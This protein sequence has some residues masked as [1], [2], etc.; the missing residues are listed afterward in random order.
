MN[1]REVAESLQLIAESYPGRWQPTKQTGQVWCR[2]LSDIDPKYG[3]AAVTELC[4]SGDW[5][6]SIAQ[7]RKT[8]VNLSRGELSQPSAWEAWERATKGDESTEIEKR[9]VNLI[10]GSWAIKRSENPEM[11][12]SQFL[13]CYSELLERHDRELCSIPVA[14]QLAESNRPE[15]TPVERR[16]SEPEKIELGTR[17]EISDMLR[18]AGF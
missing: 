6:P 4:G 15:V 10:G 16:I 3:L 8:S 14:K 12:R 17:Q 5:P 13:K 9:A 2:M 7:I 1:S 11:L 18:Q